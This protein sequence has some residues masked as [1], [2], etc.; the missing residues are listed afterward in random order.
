M[1]IVYGCNTQG[2]GHLSKAAALVPI[3]RHWGHEI[4]VVSSG[5]D[6]LQGYVFE[7]HLHVPGL[8]YVIKAGQTDYQATAARW[9]RSIP[10]M[11]VSLSR[12]KG[13]VRR[14][15]PDVILSDFEPFTASPMLGAECPVICVSRQV[16]LC[17]PDI[18]SPEGLDFDRRLARSTIRLFLIGSDR[19]FG[20]H[21]EPTTWR[22]L[23]PIIRPEL[24]GVK[25]HLGEHLF[26]Y[27]FHHCSRAAAE[28]L[29]LWA[30][31][32]VIPV[33]CYGFMRDM[34]RG[35]AGLVEFCPPGRDELLQDLASA[36]AVITTAGFTLPIEAYL[37]DKPTSVVPI[38][39]Q[40]EQL[41]N[42][43]HLQNAGMSRHLTTWD[44]DVALQTPLPD[45]NDRLRIWLKTPAE[46]VLKQILP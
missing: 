41:T 40:W 44:Y 28:E 32:R 4:H 33:K 9:A 8:E 10:N 18:P 27:N 3:L 30:Q 19:Q 1:R 42:A 22:S 13:L 39:N 24:A 34:P 12:V 43:F 16:T 35:H 23:P 11:L 38:P 15:R 26:V 46:V 20:Y 21:Y 37:L 5:P 29:I 14:V 31:H 6:A 2:Q 17:D 25:T 45:V 36:R 7:N